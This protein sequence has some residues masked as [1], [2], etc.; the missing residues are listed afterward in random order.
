M[1]KVIEQGTQDQLEAILDYHSLKSVLT[2]LSEICALKSEHIAIHWQ[3]TATAKIWMLASDLCDKA[4][5]TQVVAIV[6]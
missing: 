2:A 5:S 4:A 6:S 3:D 1:H